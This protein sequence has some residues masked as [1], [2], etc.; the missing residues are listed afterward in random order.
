MRMI[1]IRRWGTAAIWVALVAV[2][3]FLPDGMTRWF[4][5][6]DAL[7]A[8]AAVLASLAP[9]TGRLPRWFLA[10]VGAGIATLL[11][12]AL[13]SASPVGALFGRFPRYE[14]FVSLSAYFAAAWIGARLLGPRS[15]RSAVFSVMR[16]AAVVAVL[17][18]FVA[19]L[20]SLGL[21]PISSDLDRPGSLVG[22]ATDQGIVG[23]MLLVV[24]AIPVM[25]AWRPQLLPQRGKSKAVQYLTT[26][27][28]DTT[29]LTSGLV[30]ALLALILSASRGALLATA[31]GVVALAV[32]AMFAARPSGVVWWK[33]AAVGAG[34]LAVLAVAALVA[35]LTRSRLTGGSALSSQTVNDRVLIWQESAH[36]LASK[37]LAGTGPSGYADSIAHAH[38]SEWFSTVG[39]LTTLDS[40]HNVLL[41]AWAAGGAVFVLVALVLVAAVGTVGVRTLR[42]AAR[43]G[44]DSS[45]API[46]DSL[47]RIDL[48]LGAL[49]AC[50]VWAAALLTHFTAASTSILGC[51]L[52][53]AVS[54]TLPRGESRRWWTRTRTVLVIVWA[55]WL[56]ATALAEVPL[57]R[58]IEA[59]G[60]GDLSDAQTQF[61]T[62][63]ALRAWDADIRSIAAQSFAAAADGG[64]D[65]AAD[66]SLQWAEDALTGIPDNISTLKAYVVA[67]QTTGDT[68]TA[69][70]VIERLLESRPE[71][72]D[73]HLRWAINAYLE[74]DIYKARER[75]A[76]AQSLAPADEAVETLVAFLETTATD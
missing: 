6:K 4:L 73:V 43:D 68:A 33:P 25:R 70:T 52:V 37:P 76:G 36:L 19:L 54:A 42:A 21:R 55:G 71:D 10:L 12:T 1:D 51:L 22:N 14:G 3:V 47:A 5:P 53:G 41:Q 28:G 38:T 44:G 20:E 62:A 65:G 48:L 31:V 59:S 75:A 13:M 2:I 40:P 26:S 63:S 57:Q 39:A 9:A 7:L 23:A 56:G 16:A 61:E 72:A 46:R 64:V 50:A 11:V 66:L 60:R 30:G 15:T 17:L 58:G 34:G 49:A 67:L 8:I 74:K 18:G 45:T 24:L 69:E 32:L 35:P 29:L 27:A